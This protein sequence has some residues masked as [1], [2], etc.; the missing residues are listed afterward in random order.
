MIKFKFG[1]IE[2]KDF[3]DK[4]SEVPLNIQKEAIIELVINRIKK[5]LEKELSKVNY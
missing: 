5:Q 2:I 4:N 1:T 3:P